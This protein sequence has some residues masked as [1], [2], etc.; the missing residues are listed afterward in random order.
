MASWLWWHL[1][2][3]VCGILTAVASGSIWEASGKHLGC[4]LE[5]S[6][7]HL[8]AS[9]SDLG[10]TWE[11]VVISRMVSRFGEYRGQPQGGGLIHGLVLLRVVTR[12]VL[13]V[14]P[15]SGHKSV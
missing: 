7:S 4:I 14:G 1:E 6:G 12:V 9:G 5:A 13:T 8:E 2:A 10:V 11:T 3:P 15:Q